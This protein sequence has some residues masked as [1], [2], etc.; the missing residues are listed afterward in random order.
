MS[1]TTKETGREA[2]APAATNSR[3]S[4]TTQPSSKTPRSGGARSS[5]KASKGGG[6]A[7]VSGPSS[8]A[9]SSSS[10]SVAAVAA[11]VALATSTTAGAT[12]AALP[13]RILSVRADSFLVTG[14][15][16]L[17]PAFARDLERLRCEAEAAEGRERDATDPAT[18]EALTSMQLEQLAQLG[19]AAESLPEGATST[20]VV[21]LLG[22][23]PFVMQPFGAEGYEYM[24]AHPHVNLLFNARATKARPTLKVVLRPDYI[25]S[26]GLAGAW[27][28]T[29]E[30]LSTLVATR[31]DV[32]ALSDLSV[33]RIDLKADFLCSGDWVPGPSD[34]ER[35]ITRST[36][37]SAHLIAFDTYRRRKRDTGWTLGSKSNIQLA[38][39]N[40]TIELV[41]KNGGTVPEADREEWESAY[42]APLPARALDAKAS[43]GS[44]VWRLE[45]RFSSRGLRSILVERE[46]GWEKVQLRTPEEVIAAQAT[47]WSYALKRF[48][49]LVDL[50]K[51]RKERCP[52]NASWRSLLEWPLGI[53][54][55]DRCPTWERPS[56]MPMTRIHVG[57]A[58]VQQILPQSIGL[59]A[60]FTAAF[61]P[62]AVAELTKKMGGDDPTL[63][64]TWLV[65][66]AK[67][68]YLK[69][70]CATEL[71]PKMFGAALERE[72][73]ENAKAER[74]TDA[75]V[76]M[77]KIAM[78]AITPTHIAQNLLAKYEQKPAQQQ[79]RRLKIVRSRFEN[80]NLADA[81]TQRELRVLLA[82]WLLDERDALALL[83]HT[84][85]TTFGLGESESW[86]RYVF[87]GN[88]EGLER[89]R[90]EE[91]ERELAWRD[92]LRAALPLTDAVTLDDLQPTDLDFA[93]AR[94]RRDELKPFESRGDTLE[95]AAG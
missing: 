47:L 53:G 24:L 87:A 59:D 19:D 94:R 95:R 48:A 49:R 78:Q 52:M 61:G 46:R 40:K 73:A 51:S 65:A 56:V 14:R 63:G 37:G 3:G 82:G 23:R 2:G 39:Y 28:E 86:E 32:V 29:R 92:Q 79:K 6:D 15:D 84:V 71:A 45:P 64:I 44:H 30:L 11:A 58:K 9:S 36:N 1:E 25:R 35:M 7:S 41:E 93:E 16:P 50:T 55:P 54:T 62:T 89:H 75:I 22:D 26:K 10:S 83:T 68:A 81:R 4:N 77:S 38:A 27:A 69:T 31:P 21:V 60:T 5:R 43:I 70:Q 74:T 8:V 57:S 66:R 17:R 18:G 34:W 90:T 76:R 20:S 13:V 12:G 67:E 91:R 33:A 42:G 80:A 88:P 85:K 72:A